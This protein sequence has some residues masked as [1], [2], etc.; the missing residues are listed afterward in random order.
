MIARELR[1]SWPRALARILCGA[2]GAGILGGL[3]SVAFPQWS[4][5]FGAQLCGWVTLVTGLMVRGLV[6]LDARSSRGPGAD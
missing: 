1:Q 4:W 2:V 5:T 3:L 6:R